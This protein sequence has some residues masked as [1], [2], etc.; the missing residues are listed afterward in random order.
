[1][2]PV[3]EYQRGWLA[4]TGQPQRWGLRAFGIGL[5]SAG[6]ALVSLVPVLILVLW[7]E[8]RAYLRRVDAHRPHPGAGPSRSIKVAT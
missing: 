5:T 1:M 7:L 2:N 8:D 6:L 4:V 3:S